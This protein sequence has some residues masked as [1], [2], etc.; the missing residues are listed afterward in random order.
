MN[1]ER[2]QTIILILLI[3]TS[4]YLTWSIWTYEP[5]YEKIDQTKY[6]NIESD[7][8]TVSDIIKPNHILIHRF[9]Q[10][11]LASDQ[12]DIEKA[13]KQMAKWRLYNVT[14]NSSS[15]TRTQFE[16]FVHANGTTEIIFPDDVPLAL[17][18]T[19]LH[20]KDQEVP[21]FSFD[22][23]IYKQKDIHKQ[24][25]IIYF[26]SSENLNVLEATVETTKLS[27]FNANFYQNAS[28]YPEYKSYLMNN[29]HQVFVPKEQVTLNRYKYYISSLDLGN[30]KDALFTDP[31]NVRHGTV[32]GGDEYTDG[33]RLLSVNKNTHMFSYIN[34][35]QKS[36]VLSNSSDLLT[37]SI[38]F[39]NNHA[40]W[41]GS[42]YHFDHMNETNQSV[43]FRLYNA[44]YPV[45]NQIGLSEIKEI[46]GDEQIYSYQR[47]YFTLD[48]ELPSET[49]KVLMPSG[50]D[51]MKQLKLKRNLDYKNIEDVRLGYKLSIAPV[52]TN[53]ILLEPTWYYRS[54]ENWFMVPFDESGGKVN[55]LE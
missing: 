53:L 7:E 4:S 41:K 22:R 34:P 35:S 14:R 21:D 47:P 50:P 32:V 51:V 6:I 2:V 30:L 40:G 25:A 5:K 36:T 38:E 44:N 23:I 10:H 55:G 42:N 45:F 1:F 19:A 20:F 37:K 3:A 33:T 17:Y 43:S 15:L 31:M 26:A 48:F 28:I 24:K 52:D 27:D 13:E 46:W 9:Y 18:K 49:Q 29:H 12:T 11:F 54:G 39:V 8:K 16:D